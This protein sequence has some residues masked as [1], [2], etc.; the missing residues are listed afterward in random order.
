MTTAYI[1]D[2]GLAQLP[3][4][5]A[6][7]FDYHP[8][9]VAAIKENIPSRARKWDGDNKRWLFK[10]DQL[11]PV[12][13]LCF[14]YCREVKYGEPKPGREEVKLRGRGHYAKRIIPVHGFR[15]AA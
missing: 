4:R 10:V 14:L 5:W 9:L 12:E 11:Q 7:E 15:L 1:N 3:W 6:V 8:D 13:S 2:L